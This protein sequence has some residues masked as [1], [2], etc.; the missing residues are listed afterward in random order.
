MNRDHYLQ[1]LKTRFKG[2][3]FPE[4]DPGWLSI[5]WV[6]E[7]C[8]AF[9]YHF[10]LER[11]ETGWKVFVANLGPDPLVTYPTLEETASMALR[12]FRTVLEEDGWLPEEEGK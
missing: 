1:G 5:A 10:D 4:I 7:G 9:G 6:A 8:A 3:P 12:M 2:M 11:Y